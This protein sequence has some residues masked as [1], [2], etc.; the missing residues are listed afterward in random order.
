MACL[1]NYTI[2]CKDVAS[3]KTGCF[4][5][6]TDHWKKTGEFLAV[7]EIFP[8]LDTFYHGTTSAQRQSCYLERA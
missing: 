3:G 7:S 2:Q 5:F 8:D 6:D 4:L 1:T